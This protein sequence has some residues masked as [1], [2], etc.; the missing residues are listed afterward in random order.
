VCDTMRCV[1]QGGDAY[2]CVVLNSFVHVIMYAY[3]L[4]T[5]CNVPLSFIKP[6]ITQMQMGQVCACEISRT[7]DTE[8]A[9]VVSSC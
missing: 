7:C 3:Y 2:Y 1:V 8:R 4:S 9:R 5:S 6:Y